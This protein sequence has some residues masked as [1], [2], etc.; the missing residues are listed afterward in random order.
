MRKYES[1]ILEAE[2]LALPPESVRARL[3]DL[4]SGAL[5]YDTSYLIDEE[6][7]EALR[8][9][10]DPLVDLTLA[11]YG[12]HM[13]SVRPIF[14]NALPGSALRL[15]TLS[16]R[17][18]T[19]ALFS[20]FPSGLFAELEDKIQ[21]L[22]SAEE[23][24]LAALFSNPTLSDRFLRSILEQE[25]EFS[26]VPDDRF[27]YIV[28]ILAYN[29]RMS[30]PRESIYMDG[31]DEHDYDSVFQ[32]AWALSMKAELTIQWAHALCWLYANLLRKG[33]YMMKPLEVA[34]RWRPDPA[35]VALVAK[36]R[37]NTTD[38]FLSPFEMVRTGLARLAGE[39]DHKLLGD[40]LTH[41]DRAFRAAAYI[42]YPINQGN[43]DAAYERDGELVF[44]SAIG[45]E[46]LWRNVEGREM[47]R[48]LS[49]TVCNA[50]KSSHLD[51]PN[52]FRSTEQQMEKLHPEWF[53]DEPKQAEEV[54]SYE[55][56]LP[57]TKR[58][59]VELGSWL[60][61]VREGGLIDTIGKHVG[62]ILTITGL[63]AVYL[64]F[65]LH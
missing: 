42:D 53:R 45:N 7:E 61:R 22:I 1:I 30:T 2:L 15:A 34:E 13:D 20:Y 21:W 4:A 6:L 9:R 64:F 26:R 44:Q 35:N 39:T 8:L 37:E 32:A 36:D 52:Q 27:R 51:A 59:L 14:Q 10:R 25:N 54:E 33:S 11:Q 17:N 24:E 46:H 28:S 62:W 19:N 63:T 31:Q 49:W 50:D 47:L 60:S 58:D 41:E 48:S 40:L 43:I 29:K 38:G 12:R 56:D 65:K 18:F 23:V 55:D 5:R 57:G 3:M 16:N